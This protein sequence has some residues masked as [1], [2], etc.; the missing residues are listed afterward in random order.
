MTI[1]AGFPGKGMV[2]KNGTFISDRAFVVLAADSEEG[3]AVL[4]SSVRKIATIDK[5][6]C[7]CLIA[8][9][10]SGNFID[11]ATQEVE[12]RLAAP[13]SLAKVRPL[14]E[15]VVTEVHVNRIRRHFPPEQHNDLEFELL[16]AIWVKGEG[17][18]L[19]RV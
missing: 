19:V 2:D 1:V 14:L 5:G 12:R 7:K 6:D 10:G 17:V 13:F 18:Q 16:C 4:K 11:F 3:G 8:G 15:T 9:A